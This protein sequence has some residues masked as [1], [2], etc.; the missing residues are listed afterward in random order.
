MTRHF[1]LLDEAT[2]ELVNVAG[3]A[4]AVYWESSGRLGGGGEDEC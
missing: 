1:G 3:M 4:G 2:D